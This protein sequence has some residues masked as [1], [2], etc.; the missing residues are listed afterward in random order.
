MPQKKRFTAEEKVGILRELLDKKIPMS[1]LCEKYG[2]SPTVI[3]NWKKTMYETAPEALSGK[4][5]KRKKG[6]SAEQKKIE[7]LEAK[8]RQRDALIT[9]IV[10]ENIDLRKK[11][12]GPA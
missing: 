5:K 7:E 1:D 4:H 10:A 12:D 3:Y 6:K 11:Q 9:D 2:L 8:L